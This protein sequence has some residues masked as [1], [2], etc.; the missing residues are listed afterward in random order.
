MAN[1]KAPP[2]D[3]ETDPLDATLIFHEQ[4]DGR[5]VARLPGGKVVLIDLAQTDR[6]KEGEAWLV[7]LRH[8]GEKPAAEPVGST[9]SVPAASPA[10]APSERVDISRLQRATDRVALFIDGANTD[11]AARVWIHRASAAGESHSRSG[12][13][14]AHHQGKP[15]DRNRP[16]HGQHRGKPRCRVPVFRG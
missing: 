1:P 16:R 10:D 12:N 3:A 15:G 2:P 6:V 14:R 9:A 5:N 7:R 11:G 8:K 13:G 4:A